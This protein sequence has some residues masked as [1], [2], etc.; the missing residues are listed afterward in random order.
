MWCYYVASLGVPATGVKTRLAPGW[1]VS[2]ASDV[3]GPLTPGA[4]GAAARADT[5]AKTLDNG[6]RVLKTIAAHPNGL[7]MMA[8]SRATGLHRTVAYRLLVT[9]R[10]HCLVTQDA[11]GRFHLGL[12]VLE[13]SSALR[14]D[15]HTLARPHLQQLADV[16]GATVH[17]TVLDGED[18]VG[19]AIVEPANSPMHVTYRVG[20]RYPAAVGA[21]GMAILA[22]R[23]PLS[24]ERPAVTTGR[25]QGY[26]VSIGEI[27]S[28]AW[29]L[30]APISRRGREVTASVGVIA[31]GARDEAT[32]A[33]QV[34]A[35]AEA[36][37]RSLP[38]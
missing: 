25:S 34:M 26:V 15:L 22:G 1:R 24:G 31:L 29:G 30:A 10:E 6:L 11:D 36:I 5:G 17:V 21:A 8:L 3:G 2:T 35:V 4:R 38:T 37:G 20:R 27:Q 18:A 33:G 19:I 13:L 7:T 12:G 32:V 16:T 28:G 9:L 23:P 14:S